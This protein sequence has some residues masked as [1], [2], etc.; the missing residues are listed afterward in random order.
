MSKGKTV[1]TESAM[2]NLPGSVLSKTQIRALLR[3]KP[4]LIEK[5]VDVNTQLQPNGVDL[6]VKTVEKIAGAGS[7]DFSNKDRKLS[8]T[9]KQ[10]FDADWVYLSKGQYK[11][12]LNE[13]VHLPKDMMAIGA[14]RTSLIR[15]GVTVETGIWDAGY[16]G[17]SESL[18]VVFN[19]AGVRI[20]KDARVLQL[21]FIRLSNKI[22]AGEAYGGIYQSENI[23]ERQMTL[24]V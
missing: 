13:I 18:L 19:E 11:I 14:P 22:A 23:G 12:I 7:I 5:M 20:K 16:E 2:P 10:V 1:K 15:C 17:R 24:D 6:T 21:V 3:D 4:P 8:D 9:V